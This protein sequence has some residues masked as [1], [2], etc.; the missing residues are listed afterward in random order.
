MSGKEFA[1]DSLVSVI[2]P[3][4]NY[5][6][7][8]GDALRSILSQEYA[9]F[10]LIVVDD[11]ST[12]NSAQVIS[13]VLAQ[14]ADK[15]LVRRVAFLRQA[16][17]GVSAALNAGLAEARGSYIATFD[18]DDVMPAGRLSLQMAYLQDRPEVGCLGGQTQRIDERGK[19]L[20]RKDKKGGVRRYDFSQALALALVVGGNNAV[21]RRDAVEQVGGYDP[22]IK[23]Q[24]FQMTLKVAHAG[25]LVDVLP[26][27]VTLYRRH[28][29]S[30]SS[31]YKAEYR[32]GLEVIAPY[33]G[34]PNYE[35]A[36]VRLVSKALRT[37][38]VCDKTFAWSLLRQ[39]PL[40]YW[41]RRLLK[42]FRHLIL[43]RQRSATPQ[44][45]V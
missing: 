33:V 2:V 34:H 16:N 39:V 31:N 28:E 10:E 32:Y 21:Y 36:K 29:G 8:V 14:E 19:L 43:K 12:D 9:N 11:G 20:P 17:A 6:A 30:L 37:A 24:D 38:S 42:R 26:E 41:D 44:T 22:A 13:E 5:A 25:Y 1:T 15:S 40:R 23:I 35:S 27:V 45:L 4:Y 3:C 7:Y 18:A